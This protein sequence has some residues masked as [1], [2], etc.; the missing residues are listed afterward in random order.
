M[1]VNECFFFFSLAHH[2]QAHPG[3]RQ[4]A[5]QS[6]QLLG[7]LHWLPWETMEITTVMG[8][9]PE[10]ESCLPGVVSIVP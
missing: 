9:N 2:S 5:F 7:L 10:V 6:R 8:Q 4:Y 3:Q 1:L